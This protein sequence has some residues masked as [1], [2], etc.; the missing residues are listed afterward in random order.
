M[1]TDLNLS[2]ILIRI[3]FQHQNVHWRKRVWSL[4]S[5]AS[6]WI[7]KLLPFYFITLRVNC[8]YSFI[9][10][11]SFI[12]SRAFRLKNDPWRNMKS[13]C[14]FT[15]SAGYCRLIN[16]PAFVGYIQ[17][18]THSATPPV[19]FSQPALIVW[20]FVMLK[21]HRRLAFFVT[22]I[23]LLIIFFLQ[24]NYLELV[25]TS[26]GVLLGCC[27]PSPMMTHG[28][29]AFVLTSWLTVLSPDV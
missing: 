27:H 22:Q 18:G 17:H 21:C 9:E 14:V 20:D 26:A 6:A 10:A 16:Y 24:M 3:T 5:A 4:G 23:A 11:W 19:P 15:E 25:I 7:F 28:E 12:K 13:N 2:S 1:H 8:L 29:E